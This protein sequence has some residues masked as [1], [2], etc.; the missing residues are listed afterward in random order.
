MGSGILRNQFPS[1]FWP[2]M[3]VVWKGGGSGRRD[4]GDMGKG[5]SSN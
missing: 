3:S 4:G 5:C 2:C 1:I